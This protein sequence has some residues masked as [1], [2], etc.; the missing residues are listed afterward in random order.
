MILPQVLVL[1]HDLELRHLISEQFRQAQ[2]YLVGA[3]ATYPEA[4]QFISKNATDVLVFDSKIP[5]IMSADL[6]SKIRSAH[7]PTHLALLMLTGECAA[8]EKEKLKDLGV[9]EFLLMPFDRKNLLT[10][11]KQLAQKIKPPQGSLPLQSGKRVLGS[12]TLDVKSFDAYCSGDRVH[13]TPNEF[14]LLQ[15]LIEH[16]NEI[17]SREQLIDWVQG[18]GIAVVDRA[19]DTHIFSLRKK[20]GLAGEQIETIRG[21]GYRIKEN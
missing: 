12:I 4:L 3:V 6:I 20:L 7:A 8:E 10:K 1:E 2:N 21:I 5:E 19:V 9:D 13:L 16:A 17:L 14:K 18:A 15:V 11:V